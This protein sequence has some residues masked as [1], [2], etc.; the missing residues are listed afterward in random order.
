MKRS[1]AMTMAA[2]GQRRARVH[3][4]LTVQSDARMTREFQRIL[5]KLCFRRS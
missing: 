4:D 1:A 3:A 5:L 2:P